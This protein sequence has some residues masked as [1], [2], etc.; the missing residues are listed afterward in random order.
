MQLTNIDAERIVR[1]GV[2]ALQRG[3]AD[4]A[5][6]RFETIT[7]SGRANAQIWMLLAVAC[8]GTADRAAEEAALDQLLA[9]E[10]QAVRG[11]VMKG[12]CRAAADDDRAALR[13]YEIA[14]L[15]AARQDIP[16]DLRA[17]LQRAETWVDE[18]KRRVDEQREAKLTARGLPPERRSPRFQQSLDILAG[19]KRIFV[20]EPTGYY[21]PELPQVQFF[22]TG[23]FDWVPKVE[24]AAGAI[25]QEIADLLAGGIDGFRPYMQAHT[26]QPRAD[27]NALLDNRDWSALFFCENGIMSDDIVARCPATWAAVQHAPLPR[28]RNSPTVMFSLLRAGARIAPHTGTHNARLIC[29]LPL[30]VPPDCGFRVGNQVR[31]WEEGKLLI[32]DDTIEHEAWN[33]SNQ[34]RV[35]LIFD[36][37]RP[38]LSARE[39]EEIAA[40]F[41]DPAF[42]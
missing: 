40:F 22:D 6:A 14:L 38:E 1:E 26:D 17:E 29:H 39:R 13:S 5:R 25:R 31:Q 20:Q 34:D 30:I 3:Q 41:A 42:E 8:R 24:A 36:I 28:I 18:F 19:R 15:I 12:D 16:A 35:V 9:I 10:P 27:V 2:D 4:I 7:Q 33:N 37:W 32:F 11:H 23:A 21:V